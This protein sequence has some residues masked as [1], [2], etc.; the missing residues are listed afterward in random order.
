MASAS[1][2]ASIN[3]SILVLS[4]GAGTTDPDANKAEDVYKRQPQIWEVM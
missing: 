3:G 4:I 1:G 2:T